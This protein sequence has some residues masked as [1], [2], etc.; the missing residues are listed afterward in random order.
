MSDEWIE[1]HKKTRKLQ[2]KRKKISIIS[3]LI[4]VV[5]L[6]IVIIKS[7][8]IVSGEQNI[9]VL[10]PK[11]SSEIMESKDG[12]F[13]V[14]IDAGHGDFDEGTGGVGDSF[15]KNINLAISLEIGKRLEEYSDIKVVYTRDSDTVNWSDD[16]HDNLFERLEISEKA[17]ADIFI[18]I[19]CNSSY[20]DEGYKGIESWYNPL[21]VE[22]EKLATLI[23]EQLGSLEYTLDRG[24]KTYE[25]DEAL[26]VL[27]YNK[28]PA[29]LVELGFISNYS[30]QE[31]LASENG[32]KLCANAFV[33]AILEYK[34]GM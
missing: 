18:S 33:Q 34:S 24:I 29:T 17:N 14:C 2:V 23:Q 11:S 28:A 32:Q 7:K 13:I 8:N 9:G 22:G 4:L 31:F 20:E 1:K 6:F 21:S 26:V 12:K 10:K 30:D 16:S 19:H 5:F 25:E 15:E 3:A 27:E